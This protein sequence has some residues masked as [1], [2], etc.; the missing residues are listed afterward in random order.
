[1]ACSEMQCIGSILV[2]LTMEQ[3]AKCPIY[4]TH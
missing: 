4:L 1:M 2:A 3:S